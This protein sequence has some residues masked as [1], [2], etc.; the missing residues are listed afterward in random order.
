MFLVTYGCW[1]EGL[2]VFT[3]SQT[4]TQE[5]VPGEETYIVTVDDILGLKLNAQL[6][7]IN[8]GFTPY[9][10][11]FIESGYLLPSVFLAAGKIFRLL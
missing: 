11:G 7:V 10:K 2:L 4:D 3:P 1:H 8:T 6:V 9:R 5:E